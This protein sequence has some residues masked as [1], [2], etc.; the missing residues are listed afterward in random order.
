M[1]NHSQNL[2][3]IPQAKSLPVVGNLLEVDPKGIVVTLEK[4]AKKYGR[5]YRLELPIMSS[6]VVSSQEL[7][8]DVCDE[9]K[10]AKAIIKPLEI[11][12]GLAKDGLFTAYNDEP[13]WHRAH[14]I[15][16]P[17]FGPMAIRGMFPQMQDIAEQLVL[18]WERLGK[19]ARFDVSEDMTRLTLDTIALCAFDYRFNSFYTETM[20]PFI[21]AMVEGLLEA[22]DQ[23]MMLPYQKD[24]MFWKQKR[25]ESNVEYMNRVVDEIIKKR[26]TEGLENAPEDLL[27]KML[28]GKDPE[29]GEGLSDENIRYQMIT[30]L[31]AGHETTSGLLS[32]AMHLLTKHPEIL[33]KAQQQVDEIVGNEKISVDHIN[34][35]TYIDQVL[36]E[37]LRLIP[38]APAFGRE[39]KED[40]V[41]GGKY[42][43][44]RGE[45]VLVFASQLHRDPE[46]WG[47]DVESFNPDRFSEENFKKLPP[48]SWKPF[49]HGQRACIGR[50]FA[51]QEA[52][53]VLA[54][55]LQ[56]FDIEADNPDYKLKIKETLTLKPE[57]FY[58]KAK[59][60][61]ITITN[62]SDTQNTTTQKEKEI[63][64]YD[65]V[66]SPQ[67]LVLYGS[68]TG[69][70]RAFAQ[71]LVGDAQRK[72]FVA[73]LGELDNYSNKLPKESKI[74]IVT[75]SY[76]GAPTN[77]AKQFVAWL[78]EGSA[79]LSGLD[80]AVMGCGNTDWA[81]TYQAI[82]TFID[83]QMKSLGATAFYNRGEA[84]AK[85]D[86]M[87]SFEAWAEGLWTVLESQL[88]VSDNVPTAAPSISVVINDVPEKL[89]LLNQK[90]LQ[91]GTIVENKEL[92]DIT[93]ELGRSKR[94]IEIRLPAGMNYRAGD[95][96]TLLPTNPEASIKRVLNYFSLSGESQITIN[97][98][99]HSHLPSDNP[100][101]IHS[102]LKH[103]V[104]L[105]QP[106]AK[107]ILETL[108]EKT[109]CP[110]EAQQ[111][112]AWSTSETYTKEVLGKRLSLIDV[113]EQFGSCSIEFGD[114]LSM[115]PPMQVRQYS[116]S[117]SAMIDPTLCSLTVAI[118]NA[119]ALSG[120]GTYLGVASNYLASLSKGDRILVKTTAS[121]EA[122]HIPKNLNVPII[123]VGAGSGLAPLRGFLQELSVENPNQQKAVLFFGCDHP[124]VD[125]MY[126]EE[127]D[128]YQKQG[129]VKVYP[130]FTFK[131]IDDVKFVQHRI[132]KEEEIVWEA[133]QND[134]IIFVCGDGKYMAPAVKITL[135]DIY[136]SKTNC[137]DSEA[138]AWMDK[139]IK[140]ER[141]VLDAF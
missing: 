15:L 70:S 124:D 101:S 85:G 115:L 123:M 122:F 55:V 125:F 114:F 20:H 139:L 51:M 98:N 10:F 132:K 91:W 57:G 135:I 117:S 126:K 16:T 109:P 26:K 42:Q 87:G 113:L 24:L 53:L 17:A 25:F 66:E 77:N 100:I 108:A 54:M 127:F 64:N 69:S 138:T 82:P 49:G 89:S 43:I 62:S 22:G 84:D 47:N 90:D 21:N 120:K 130:A 95:Y 61:N 23:L 75:A 59:R 33:K 67:I 3:P 129:I 30:F 96:L 141:Y 128:I 121:K 45:Q 86:F 28:S 13:N 72:G 71:Q 116:I 29:T 52:I 102:L 35:L 41:I 81:N 38:T 107:H 78:K 110:P 93:H 80:F 48:N 8:N 94:H 119:P 44:K 14:R 46:V 58:I 11:V 111:L 12:R 5:I 7:V 63:I 9:T 50:P 104:E 65:D 19:N 137:S 88:E 76:D 92:V 103:Y 133:L 6:I 27:N 106:V 39:A 99:S 18:K 136:K 68:N 37:T 34:K 74:I 4:L 97:G 118:V 31:I 32:F 105:G 140:E 73:K 1:K 2:K 36:K 60:R 131:V 83:Q 79:D 40:V 112:K 134:A 56:R